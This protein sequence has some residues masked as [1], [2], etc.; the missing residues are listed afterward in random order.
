MPMLANQRTFLVNLQVFAK[1]LVFAGIGVKN[2]DM[3]ETSQVEI[4][5]NQVGT[6]VPKSSHTWVMGSDL[7]L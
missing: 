6:T 4:R 7:S 3:Y 1:Y 2:A 5:R